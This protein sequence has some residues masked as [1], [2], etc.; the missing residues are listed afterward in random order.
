MVAVTTTLTT[1]FEFNGAVVKVPSKTKGK[2][3]QRKFGNR[4]WSAAASNAQ[5]SSSFDQLHRLNQ[6]VPL[7]PQQQRPMHQQHQQHRN[8]NRCNNSTSSSRSNMFSTN[9]H[10]SSHQQQSQQHSSIS[11]HSNSSRTASAHRTAA[12]ASRTASGTIQWLACLRYNN[13][14]V[15]CRSAK[16]AKKMRN[17]DV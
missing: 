2:R 9:S 8:N 10:S 7:H 5:L 13:T 15:S 11:Q 6:L 16:L 14:W 1:S 12:T 17:N 4:S 3:S